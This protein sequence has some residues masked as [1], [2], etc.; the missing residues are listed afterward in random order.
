MTVQVNLGAQ[1]N[2]NSGRNGV[3][4]LGFLENKKTSNL[5]NN[6]RVPIIFCVLKVKTM[7]SPGSELFAVGAIQIS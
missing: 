1:P 6:I 7:W 5:S 2:L 4:A 3:V